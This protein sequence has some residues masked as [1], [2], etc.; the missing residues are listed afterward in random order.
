MVDIQCATPEIREEKK[1]K[2]RK[3]ERI[4]KKIETRNY[5]AKI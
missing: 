1:Q 3:K 5:R 2:E 4:T